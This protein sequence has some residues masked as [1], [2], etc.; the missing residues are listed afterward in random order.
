MIIFDFS[1][2]IK[3]GLSQKNSIARI[4]EFLR[5]QTPSCFKESYVQICIKS[6]ETV[7]IKLVRV[8]TFI[9]P[10]SSP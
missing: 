1:V 3:N 10:I 8:H 2:E 7:A 4:S 5:R 6:F 9:M